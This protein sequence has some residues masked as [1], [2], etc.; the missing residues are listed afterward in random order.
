[1][2]DTIFMIFLIMGIWLACGSDLEERVS[3][4]VNAVPEQQ[5]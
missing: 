2:I 4:E 3:A 1:V 5:S